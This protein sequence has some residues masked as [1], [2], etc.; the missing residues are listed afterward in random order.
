MRY[1][2]STPEEVEEALKWKKWKEAEAIA[3]AKNPLALNTDKKKKEDDPVE[4]EETDAKEKENAVVE[5]D[6]NPQDEFKPKYLKLDDGDAKEVQK[7]SEKEDGEKSN[8]ENYT[9]SGL[10]NIEGGT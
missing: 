8:P 4:V 7:D 10:K 6:A 2:V 9:T 5:I 1:L 3:K